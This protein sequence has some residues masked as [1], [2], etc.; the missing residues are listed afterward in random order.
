MSKLDFCLSLHSSAENEKRKQTVL[1]YSFHPSQ[2][3]GWA[4]PEKWATANPSLQNTAE[5]C[6]FLSIWIWIELALHTFAH[7]QILLKCAVS[8]NRWKCRWKLYKIFLAKIEPRDDLIRIGSQNRHLG[9]ISA[10][11]AIIEPEYQQILGRQWD[12]HASF[13]KLGGDSNINIKASILVALVLQVDLNDVHRVHLERT[14]TNI[15]M[16]LSEGQ[17]RTGSTI[18]PSCPR[19]ERAIS[20]DWYS[21]TPLPGC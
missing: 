20:A 16:K 5:M 15:N 3:L 1:S 9:N 13:L 19:P 18:R 17:F 11:V 14:W 4:N 21:Y 7:I 12:C 6:N 10:I 2:W 8:R